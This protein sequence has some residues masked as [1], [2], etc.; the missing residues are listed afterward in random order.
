MHWV[1]RGGVFLPHCVAVIA[2]DMGGMEEG[3]WASRRTVCVSGS[4]RT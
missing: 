4:Q 2:D 3:G 1:P